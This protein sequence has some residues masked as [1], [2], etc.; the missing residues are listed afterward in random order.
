MYQIFYSL[1][2]LSFVFTS[3]LS[4]IYTLFYRRLLFEIQN[5]R[6][7]VIHLPEEIE[8]HLFCNSSTIS[9]SNDMAPERYRKRMHRKCINVSCT[10]H[11]RR[12]TWYWE[13]LLRC[14]GQ[15]CN[16]EYETFRLRPI[17]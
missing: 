8:P 6:P 5:A 3:S 12:H 16:G 14:T 13:T 1:G 15:G 7:R 4:D 9:R 17:C 2:I 11:R 10:Y